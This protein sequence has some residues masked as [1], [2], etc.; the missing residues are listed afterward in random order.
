ML[1]TVPP[2]PAGAFAEKLITKEKLVIKK[3]ASM[4]YEEAAILPAIGVTAWRALVL[5]GR[6]KS[7]QAV[8]VNGALG[9]VGQA[10]VYIAKALGASVTGRVGPGALA[11]AK[12]I[13]IDPVVAFP[14]SYVVSSRD[15]SHTRSALHHL[16][17]RPPR[18]NLATCCRWR[19]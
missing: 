7:G 10:A 11:D 17:E 18:H 19:G 4:S 8:F 9:G 2:A 14:S 3:P 12:A 5:Q 1:G 15:P 6:L 13:G 16:H